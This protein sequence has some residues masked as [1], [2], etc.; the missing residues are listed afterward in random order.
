MGDKRQFHAKQ[1]SLP[2]HVMDQLGTRQFILVEPGSKPLVHHTRER[3]ERN[4]VV[5][6]TQEHE[7]HFTRLLGHAS[8]DGADPL[9]PAAR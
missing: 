5:L 6:P 7:R 1:S 3:P 2:R 4:G 8:K 9:D